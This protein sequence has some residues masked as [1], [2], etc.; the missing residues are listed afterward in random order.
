MW[1]FTESGFVSAV[2]HHSIEG[3]VHVRAR[4]RKSLE[5][6]DDLVAAGI[7]HTPDAD[8]PYR[9][10]VPDA[11]FSAWLTDV[12]ANLEYPNFK[13]QVAQVRGYGF[14]GALHDVWSTMHQVEDE[15]ARPR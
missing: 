1:V 4:D 3:V 2:R 9:L 8:Y 11:E 13:D 5:P 12:V 6:L 15:E 10:D 14:A 7:V